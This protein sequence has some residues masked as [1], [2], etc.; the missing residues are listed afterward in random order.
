M[1][2]PWGQKFI[3]HGHAVIKCATSVGMHVDMITCLPLHVVCYKITD[4]CV[5]L[6]LSSTASSFSFRCFTRSNQKEKNVKTLK[7]VFYDNKTVKLFFHRISDLVYMYFKCKVAAWPFLVL[8]FL[9]KS[10]IH[11]FTSVQLVHVGCCC[12][13]WIWDGEFASSRATITPSSS[14]VSERSTNAKRNP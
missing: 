10:F 12:R 1:R 9:T 7:R 5:S 13:W 8:C 11:S 6:S 4:D 3:A 14:S 2:W